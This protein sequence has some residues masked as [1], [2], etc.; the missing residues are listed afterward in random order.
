MRISFELQILEFRFISTQYSVE[1]TGHLSYENIHS[2][3]N[4]SGVR[5]KQNIQQMQ[6]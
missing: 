5:D 1:H 6:K 2:I 3:R 4:V